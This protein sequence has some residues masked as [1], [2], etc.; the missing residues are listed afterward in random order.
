MSRLCTLHG[1]RQRRIPSFS[2]DVRA[3]IEH[4]P[5]EDTIAV[6]AWW[7]TLQVVHPLV[8]F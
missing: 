4:R 1:L 3:E 8:L 2:I 7:L 5:M 6:F